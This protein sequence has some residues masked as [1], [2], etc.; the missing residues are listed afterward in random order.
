MKLVIDIRERNLIES[1][2]SLIEKNITFKDIIIETQNLEVGD[3]LIKNEKDIDILII[4]R[5]T[6]DD[7][8]SSI[9]DGRY[10]EQ[11]FRLNGI[12][13]ENHNIIYL[14]EGPIKNNYTEKQMIYSSLFSINYYKGF[15]VHRSE[16][17]NE[18]A[19]ILLNMC[20][21]LNKEKSKKPFYQKK[22]KKEIK[23]N[24]MED[25]EEES[26]N[27]SENGEPKYCSVIK[28]KKN[29]NITTENFG[30]IILCQ[31]PQVSSVT[32]IAIMKEFN[33][34]NNLLQKIKEDDKCLDTI[35]YETSKGQKRK[36]SK[37]C[38]K[39]IIDYL[40]KM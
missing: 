6:I 28:K 35:T 26:E 8:V 19:Y 15:S 29:A 5:K 12:D 9:K 4:E 40:L 39:N 25:N 18:S 7:L 30:E 1:C 36:L 24:I 16:N 33:T 2:K 21:K 13:H 31:V 17:I 14:I 22:T 10:S 32:S 34:L 11:S 20:A 3:I 38:I 23:E 37:T 27:I